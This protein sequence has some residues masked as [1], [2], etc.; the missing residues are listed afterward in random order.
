MRD[1]S[2]TAEDLPGCSGRS[3]ASLP[4]P[5]E[6]S[7]A[8]PRPAP[9]PQPQGVARVRRALST[10]ENWH[11]LLKFGVVGGS[12]YVVNLGVFSLVVAG[13][14][15]HHVLGAA[16]AFLVAVTNNFWWNRHWTFSQRDRDARHQASR[17]LV[18]NVISFVFQVAILEFLVSGLG[19]S[20]VPAQAI[21][22]GVATP[23]NFV[24]NKIWS[25]GRNAPARVR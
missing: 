25:F 22:V 1:E 2:E 23:F 19:A 16:L 5:P 9:S 24:G 6:D 3:L 17:Y 7:Y 4:V 18:I 12:G 11:Q 13:F 15:G 21:S 10:Q 14:G 8:I 20:E